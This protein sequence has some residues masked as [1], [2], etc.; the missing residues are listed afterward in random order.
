M[1]IIIAIVVIVALIFYLNRVGGEPDVEKFTLNQMIRHVK[2]LQQWMDR[3]YT[4]SNP[5]DAMKAE[6]HRKNEQWN[7][8]MAVWKRKDEEAI[9]KNELNSLLAKSAGVIEKELIPITD[10][11][12]QL[13]NEGISEEQAISTILKEWHESNKSR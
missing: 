4:I 2:S 10:R 11:I 9:A 12:N 7:H 5:S 6:F 13:I 8:A 1:G 3:Y